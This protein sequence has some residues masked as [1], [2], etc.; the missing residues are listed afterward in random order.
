[1][2][3]LLSNSNFR[4]FLD[5]SPMLAFVKEDGVYRY[6][7]RVF[8]RVFD[9]PEEFFIG[10]TD[11]ELYSEEVAQTLMATDADILAD[12][13]PREIVEQVPLPSGMLQK[14]LVIKF[15]M[16]ASNG[17]C[18]LG[19]VAIK[20]VLHEVQEY[21]D[22]LAQEMEKQAMY[23][24]NSFIHGIAHEIKS[25]LQAI[26]NVVEILSI[27]GSGAPEQKF[28][29]YLHTIKSSVGSIE[30][31]IGNIVK[32]GGIKNIENIEDL[33]KIVVDDRR[34]I[35]INDLVK[36]TVDVFV[37]STESKEDNVKVVVNY[38]EDVETYT[39]NSIARQ[40]LINLMS[41]ALKAIKGKKNKEYIKKRGA[42]EISIR[43]E[44]SVV[45]IEVKDNGVGIPDDKKDKLFRPFYRAN[46][47]LP[48]TGLGLYYSKVWATAA[49][50]DLYL[51]S[52]VPNCTVFAL[53]IP[54]LKEL[55]YDA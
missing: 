8:C 36:E 13:E 10:K 51:K 38:A 23:S 11:E 32:F 16:K 20:D 53:S 3:V 54:V 43:K 46:R 17:K 52:S 33:S 2:D 24:I 6:V 55:S 27:V 39:S 40:I 41:N 45:I 12:G 25:P 18:L 28:R 26:D 19:G 4:L 50:M 1:M 21:R 31:I 49:N 9:E 34:L 47:D 30:S 37:Y 22:Y 42:I 29:E 14:W 5:N 35:N 7:N 15:P 48:G 44:D